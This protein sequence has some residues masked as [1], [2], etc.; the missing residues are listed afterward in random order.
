MGN[1]PVPQKRSKR[2]AASRAAVL[3]EELFAT[4]SESAETKARQDLHRLA[5][6]VS[7]RA[8]GKVSKSAQD[9]GRR[10]SS[11]SRARIA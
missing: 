4:L 2:D 11:R 8:R 6:V 7:R 10:R 1:V 9:A 3:L 5:S